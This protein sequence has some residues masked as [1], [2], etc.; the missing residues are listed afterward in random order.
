MNNE[1]LF[2]ILIEQGFSKGDVTIF[3]KY[4]S[5]DFIENQ[6]GMKPQNVEGVKMP[7]DIFTKHLRTFH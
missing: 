1:Q 3:D 2:R 7:S 4:T 6:H 5:P